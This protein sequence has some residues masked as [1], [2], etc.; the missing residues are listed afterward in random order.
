MVL[1]AFLQTAAG[2]EPESDEE[3]FQRK[4]E[5][6]KSNNL[7][8]RPLGEIIDAVGRSF[9]GTTYVAHSLEVPGEER[10]VVN[11]RAFDCLTFVESTLA[12][13]RCIRTRTASFE[14]FRNELQ[15]VRYRH[16]LID[17]YPSRLHY[18]SEWIRDNELKNIV[19]EVTGE[20]GG[21]AYRKTLKFMSTHRSSYA[22]LENEDVVQRIEAT[23]KE[24]SR[25]SLHMI[26][27]HAVRKGE[28][29]M[30]SGDIVALATSREGIDV[31]HTGLAVVSEGRVRYL[32]APLSGG[33][34]QMSPGSLSEY[35][36]QGAGSLIGIMVARPL[37]PRTGR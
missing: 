23:E 1:P 12:I 30:R 26:P 6:A 16:G 35:V 36:Q 33:T 11:L 34:V 20:L 15:Q 32:H 2:G 24:I 31:S 37:E 3:I 28:R 9:L 8:D 21:K 5:L 25:H 22:Q 14:S 13:S 4:L 10:L 18:F 17:G 29:A 19:K 27:R 7:S